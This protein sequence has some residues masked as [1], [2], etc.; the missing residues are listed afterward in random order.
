MN[1]GDESRPKDSIGDSARDLN[2]VDGQ[3]AALRLSRA[4]LDALIKN[5]K[6]P[7]SP[8]TTHNPTT[9]SYIYMRVQPF[10]APFPLTT[11][12]LPDNTETPTDRD[13]T[14]HLQFLLHLL[15]PSHKLVHSTVTQALPASWISI[16]DQYDWVEDLVAESLRVGVEVLGQEYIVARMG[17]NQHSVDAPTATA[18]PAASATPV[19]TAPTDAI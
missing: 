6:P 14:S 3:E 12:S 11:Q 1:R 13:D 17:W 16:W 7:P 18:P 5:A 4:N 19:P 10:I 15:D 8:T 9:H 2:T